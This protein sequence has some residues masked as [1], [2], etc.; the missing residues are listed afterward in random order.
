MKEGLAHFWMRFTNR[1]PFQFALMVV[2]LLI[3][4]GGTSQYIYR[5]ETT[6]F[7]GM[8]LAGVVLGWLLGWI[9][10]PGWMA[11]IVCGS[12]AVWIPLFLV[13]R[14]DIPL[15]NMIPLGLDSIWQILRWQ[16]LPQDAAFSLVGLIGRFASLPMI[17]SI[18]FRQWLQIV[19]AGGTSYDP[20]AATLAWS[21]V[22]ILAGI[23]AGW[24]MRVRNRVM[25]AGMPACA[26]LSSV[27]YHY[28][29]DH[30]YIYSIFAVLL[31]LLLIETQ[32]DRKNHWERTGMDY[33]DNIVYDLITSVGPW[34]LV[35]LIATAVVPQMDLADITQRIRDALERPA[36]G[37]NLAAK[38]TDVHANNPYGD[39]NNAIPPTITRVLALSTGPTLSRTL[40]LEV[41]VDASPD[42]SQKA[43]VAHAHYWRTAIYD[44]YDGHEWSTSPN[45]QKVYASNDPV[46]EELP[47]GFALTQRVYLVNKAPGE[48]FY[49]GVLYSINQPYTVAWRSDNDPF[50]VL[51]PNREYIVVSY[52]TNASESE[53]RATG[54]NYPQ[55]IRDRYLALPSS[56]PRRIVSLAQEWTAS[57]ITPYDQA[58]AIQNHLR[59]F[60]YSL[61]VPP[62]PYDRDPVDYFLF[63]RNK[64]YCNYFASAMVLLARSSGVPARIVTGYAM[65]SFDETRGAFSVVEADAHTWPELYFEGIG[66]VEFEPTPSLPAIGRSSSAEARNQETMPTAFFGKGLELL[67]N[68]IPYAVMAASGAIL[69]FLMLSFANFFLYWVNRLRLR[70]M[71]PP[72]ALP[73]MFR[74]LVRQAKGLGIGAVAGTTP[75]EF[76]AALIRYSEGHPGAVH[77]QNIL[78]IILGYS[79]STYGKAT[80]PTKGKKEFYLAWVE[81]DGYLRQQ[82]RARLI[83]KIIRTRTERL[84]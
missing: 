53:L 46:Y 27:L 18:R 3:V 34:L 30:W 55:W 10:L 59:Q 11:G 83:R 49:S 70:W 38:P 7:L 40:M 64:G 8:M 78:R 41:F 6:I 79:D 71:A 80:L 39:Q 42:A 4:F 68:L 1:R 23:F 16:S 57:A 22:F 45:A 25:V 17:E 56:M 9:P 26:L 81:I 43:G 37:E 69:V 65:G 12:C 62:A 63:D 28:Q 5:V 67:Q 51:I 21:F 35:I 24:V 82:K 74:N 66:W 14:M 61:D 13:G 60:E 31:V 20:L 44:Q 50:L 52:E 73:R 47:R 15:G 36:A 32:W 58:L 72:Q 19:M 75:Q 33:S 54:W 77:A 29:G 84:S 48:A 76:G 2:L